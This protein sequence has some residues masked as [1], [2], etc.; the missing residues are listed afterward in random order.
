MF[1]VAWMATPWWALYWTAWDFCRHGQ[2]WLCESQRTA[3]EIQSITN[4]MDGFICGGHGICTFSEGE[5][6]LATWNPLPDLLINVTLIWM[7]NRLS[8]LGMWSCSDC[9]Y[10]CGGNNGRI[11]LAKTSETGLEPAT[12][13]LGG[14]RASIAPH[15]L[16]FRGETTSKPKLSL[17]FQSIWR[18]TFGPSLAWLSSIVICQKKISGFVREVLV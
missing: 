2:S 11:L 8:I 9:T 1:F 13:A 15:R 18:R 4:W 14:R 17:Y 10:S 16:T 3:N 5:L 6:R 12:F 7:M